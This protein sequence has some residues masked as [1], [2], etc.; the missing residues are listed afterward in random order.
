M[1]RPAASSTDTDMPRAEYE[2]VSLTPDT[3]ETLRHVLSS[4]RVSG[5]DSLPEHLRPKRGESVTLSW[6]VKAGCAALEEAR[7]GAKKPARKRAVRR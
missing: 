5:T 7:G 6:L 1:T 4:I 3:A 2:S